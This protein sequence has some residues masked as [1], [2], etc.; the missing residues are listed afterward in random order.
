MSFIT[1]WLLQKWQP[2]RE[3]IATHVRIMFASISGQIV[4][5]HLMDSIY[6]TTTD[7]TDPQAAVILNARRSVIQELLEL[8]DRNANPNKYPAPKVE[9]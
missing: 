5:Q 2:P 9:G 6:C 8:E 1:A 4:K 3:D 7:N